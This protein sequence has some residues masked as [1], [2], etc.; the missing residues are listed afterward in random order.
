M[1]RAQGQAAGCLQTPKDRWPVPARMET[2][3]NGQAKAT[4]DA[5]IGELKPA[6]D[7]FILLEQDLWHAFITETEMTPQKIAGS[8]ER[9]LYRGVELRE[10]AVG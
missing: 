1:D 9:I 7:L 6:D 5:K 3:V 10:S 2:P 4:V 8:D